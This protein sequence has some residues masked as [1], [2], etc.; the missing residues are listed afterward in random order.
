MS[1]GLL[2]AHRAFDFTLCLISE[3]QASFLARIAI[4]SSAPEG[5]YTLQ[6]VINDKEKITDVFEVALSYS[7]FSDLK[8][9]LLLLIIVILFVGGM[10]WWEVHKVYQLDLQKI[11]RRKCL[12]SKKYLE[13][14]YH[15]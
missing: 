1:R 2:Q 11:R 15:L 5:S 10:I 6:V 13:K 9:Y 7:I 14:C 12:M 3:T 8:Y 4:P